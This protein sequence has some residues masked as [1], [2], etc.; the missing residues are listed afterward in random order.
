MNEHISRK[1]RRRM[2]KAIP[3]LGGFVPQ[4]NGKAPISFTEYLLNFK[5]DMSGNSLVP[6][7][8]REHPLNKFGKAEVSE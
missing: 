7:R 4:Y 1:I 6:R 2:A 5:T 3:S 8:L